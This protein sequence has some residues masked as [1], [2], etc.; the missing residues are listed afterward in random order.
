MVWNGKYRVFVSETNF[1][2][3]L[4]YVM[5]SRDQLSHLIYSRMNPVTSSVDIFKRRPQTTDEMKDFI[6]NE[7]TAIPG[8]VTW[9]VLRNLRG[10]RDF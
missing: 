1:F 8:A 7:I 5:T 9:R 4:N 2:F 6:C 10:F 3:F